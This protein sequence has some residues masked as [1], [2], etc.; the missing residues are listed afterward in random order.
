MTNLVKLLVA[1]QSRSIDSSRCCDDGDG[2]GHDEAT[3]SLWGDHDR[4]GMLVRG[5]SSRW[6]LATMWGKVS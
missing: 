2:C 3:N 1:L 6:Q 5:W 4:N